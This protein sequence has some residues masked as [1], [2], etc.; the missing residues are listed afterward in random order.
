MGFFLVDGN[1]RTQTTAAF[2]E[3][4]LQLLK[5]LKENDISKE[6][7][8]QAKTRK[9]NS[10]LADIETMENRVDTYIYYKYGLKTRSDFLNNYIKSIDAITLD[11]VHQALRANIHL[12]RLHILVYGHPDI[13]EALNKV[14]TITKTLSF[15]EYFQSELSLKEKDPK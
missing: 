6:E 9:K 15:E 7:L 11:E 1:S 10:F 5:E 14:K 8:E 3:G 4:I 2:L 13:K 12:D